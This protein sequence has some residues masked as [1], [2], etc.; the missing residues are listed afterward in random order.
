MERKPRSSG[1]LAEI[2]HGKQ[3]FGAARNC[4]SISRFSG[5]LLPKSSDAIL[6]T[7]VIVVENARNKVFGV[8]IFWCWTFLACYSNIH[9]LTEA[10]ISVR[11]CSGGCC[12]CVF[13]AFGETHLESFSAE[14]RGIFF[15]HLLHVL[16][17]SLGFACAS[18]TA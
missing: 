9:L 5:R 7:R 10:I 4:R 15:P 17:V 18:A 16:E 2:A 14:N 3:N 13:C 11:R 6:R 1:K 8:E 12:K